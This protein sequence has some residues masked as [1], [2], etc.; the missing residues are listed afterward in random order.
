MM[1][2]KPKSFRCRINANDKTRVRVGGSN[3]VAIEQWR[4]DELVG[5]TYLPAGAARGLAQA[6]LNTVEAHESGERD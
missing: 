1:G 5:T 4:N 2:H 6:I 3:A